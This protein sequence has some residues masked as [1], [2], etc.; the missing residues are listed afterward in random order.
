MLKAGADLNY[1][2]SEPDRLTWGS[3]PNIPRRVIDM[4]ARR[5]HFEVVTLLMIHGALL[6]G[7]TLPCAVASGNETLIQFL[8]G[9]G[10]DIN[11][12]GSLNTTPLAAAIQLQNAR[13]IK[14]LEKHGALTRLNEKV[15][16][17][18]ALRATS[19]VGN[20][21]F[22]KYL[23]Q[24]GGMVNPKDLGY[25]LTIAIRDG[26]DEVARILIDTGA[27]VNGDPDD[28]VRFPRDGDG[29]RLLQVLKRRKA[30]L[31]HSLLD[32]GANAD[33]FD[34]RTS[35]IELAAEWGDHSVMKA[36]IFAGAGVDHRE[37]SRGSNTALAIAVKR[38]DRAL[39]QLL[40]DSG[41]DVNNP[42]SRIHGSTALEAAAKNGDVSM[43]R[44]LF[45]QGADPDDPWALREASLQSAELFELILERYDK[46]YSKGRLGFG[47]DVLLQAIMN[48]NGPDVSMMLDRG[49]DAN[50]M[51]RM[52]ISG[53]QW[54]D[55]VTPFGYAILGEQ[56]SIAESMGLFLL[57]GC[58]PNSI[59]SQTHWPNFVRRTALLAAVGTRNASK[60]EL[61]LT[62]G[63]DINLPARGP[64][65][66]TPLQRAAEIGSVEIVE[67]LIRNGAEVNA[68]AAQRSRATALQFAAIGGYI[69]VACALLNLKADV[70]APSSKMN[71]RTALEGAAEHGRLDMVKV[72]LN[73]G[74]GSKGTD[75]A[76]FTRAIKLA[77]DSGFS[78]ICDLLEAH[79]HPEEHGGELDML[80]DVNG[81][82][83]IDWDQVEGGSLF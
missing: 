76:Q 42:A 28:R 27:D 48:G 35:A 71:G 64:I 14:I 26:Q 22:I 4:A 21:P 31:V 50:Q 20:V 15:Y 52:D 73:A 39:V 32:V 62:W 55:S 11:S 59:V 70:D 25:A 12:I 66:R 30:D 1:N 37:N 7:N 51:V 45:D 57:K 78:Y 58:N 75:H 63:A 72:L 8:L 67:L 47:S 54:L 3:D 6:T 82:D 34:D 38:Q 74:A 29:P 77:K 80:Y 43:A 83:I 41:A 33:R 61:L 60:V 24:F 19:E 79:L 81:D 5:G 53:D 49:F 68:P 44:Y 10:A 69:P 2:V 23:I 65:K 40:L 56:L 17:F 18:V 13:I 46:R 16:L 36:L 9:R